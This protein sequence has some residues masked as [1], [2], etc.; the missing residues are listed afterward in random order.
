MRSILA[1]RRLRPRRG[2]RIA[3][4]LAGAIVLAAIGGVWW[5]AGDGGAL[6][7][8]M[9]KPQATPATRPAIAAVTTFAYR[10]APAFL[11]MTADGHDDGTVNYSPASMWMALAIAARGA[12]GTTRAQ[13][14]AVLESGALTDAD[15]RSLANSINGRYPASRSEMNAANSLWIDDGYPLAYDYLSSVGKDFDAQ[16]TTL[17]FND[18][19][20][21]RMGDWISRHTNGSMR[22]KI[23][24]RENEVLSIIN[25]VHASGRWREAFERRLTGNATFHGESAHT[26][27]PMMHRSFTRMAHGHDERNTWQRV[28]IPFDNGGGLIIVLPAEGHFDE[29]AGDA[30]KLEWAFGACTSFPLGARTPSC[31]ADGPPGWNVSV[32]SATVNVS[33]PRFAIESTFD[34]S[35]V[36]T[37]L[38]KLGVTDA[39]SV[40]DAD[41]SIMTGPRSDGGN[42]HIGSI[43][44]GTRIAVDEAGAKAAGF[45]KL[46]VEAISA[47]ADDVEFT[48]DRP[49]L[50]SFVTPDGVPLFIGAVRNLGV[51]D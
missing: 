44:Q 28:E 46:G 3:A 16:V 10:T 43:L 5:T 33:L 41:F 26:Q 11:T 35:D 32:E 13:L 4:I 9:V 17:P 23:T 30:R 25:A 1:R 2:R 36:I 31:A 20:A 48:A 27:V 12:G 38:K 14:D 40:N 18:R 7:R 34:S 21:K 45:V 15:Y 47:P 6:V 22:P 50:Y 51:K 8:N 24:L 39:F 49:F 29:L 37:A 42:L 19:A